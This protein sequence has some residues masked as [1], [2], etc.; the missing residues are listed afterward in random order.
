MLL[1]VIHTTCLVSH[2][3]IPAVFFILFKRVQEL[4]TAMASPETDS[5]PPSIPA[6]GT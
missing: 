4:K 6:P 1:D 3:V 5:K 2:T